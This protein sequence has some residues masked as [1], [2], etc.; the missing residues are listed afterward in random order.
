MIELLDI[1]AGFAICSSKDHPD[2]KGELQ[3]NIRKLLN[4][5]LDFFKKMKKIE[6]EEGFADLIVEQIINN[7]T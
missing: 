6:D 7:N 3:Q 2:A 1:F 5:D 4:E